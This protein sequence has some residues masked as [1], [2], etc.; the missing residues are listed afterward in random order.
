MT[1]WIDIFRPAGYRWL[2]R[3]FPAGEFPEVAILPFGNPDLFDMSP[4]LE[5]LDNARKVGAFY[6][7]MFQGVP[8]AVSLSKLGAPAAALAMDVLAM[9]AV[10]RV[11][12]IGY[13]GGLQEDVQCG[14]LVIPAWA[15][16]DESASQHY[17]P[18]GEYPADA[19]MAGALARRC[20]SLDYRHHVGGL[21]TTDG[22]LRETDQS[23][24]DWHSRGLLA[25]DMETS[26]FYAV[27]TTFG[28]RAAAIH[29]ASDNP[30]LRQPTDHRALRDGYRRAVGIL[31]D[32]IAP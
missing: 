2:L 6:F 5:R 27:A 24:A 4:L 3:D 29:A 18:I 17:R 7:G 19:E 20:Q 8:V 10:T 22:I 31:F 12:A 13:C 14:D 32:C 1:T 15:L 11:F 9:T 16:G 25:V 21:W 23:V 30:F 28:K 26:A